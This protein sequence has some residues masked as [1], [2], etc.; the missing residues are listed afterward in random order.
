VSC[1]GPIAVGTAG[2]DYYAGV[3][4]D[5]GHVVT[6]TSEANNTGSTQISVLEAGVVDLRVTAMTC[7]PSAVTAGAAVSCSVTIQN[8]GSVD[9]AAFTNQLRFSADQTINSAD[10]LLTN[11]GGGALAAGTSTTITCAG[12][13]GAGT[14]VGNDYL[15]VVVDSAG[16][17]AEANETNNTASAP[18]AV[19]APG[20]PDL[21]VTGIACSPGSGSFV[22]PGSPISCTATVENLGAVAAGAFANQLQFNDNTGTVTLGT[23][24]I[25][26]LAPGQ[27]TNVTCSGNIPGSIVA[28]SYGVEMVADTGGAIAEVNEN[29]N[30][31]SGSSVLYGADIWVP[32]ITCPA[33]ST[34]SSITCSV[35]FANQGN[36]A[37]GPFRNQVI[38]YWC[39]TSCTSELAGV[40]NVGSIAPGGTATVNCTGS[41]NSFL[42]MHRMNIW[43]N[44]DRAVPEVGYGDNDATFSNV[45]NYN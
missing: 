7:A 17:V 41:V 42:L 16:S 6:E 33:T 31:S 9:S 3:I 39:S 30:G 45:F 11:C 12:N 37:T 32:S 2:R 36:V 4:V 22:M 5:S 28:G 35:V 13:I 25:A 26:G 21:V 10:T 1:S 40:C 38:D 18:L 8:L 44:D 24:N 43:A 15:G 23:C 19:V 29:N 20:A 34:G 27:A 14:A